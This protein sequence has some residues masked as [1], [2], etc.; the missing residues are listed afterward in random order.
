MQLL[1]SL[2]FKN[3]RQINLFLAAII[4]GIVSYWN[5]RN[6]ILTTPDS[7]AYWEGSISIIEGNKFAFLGGGE[8]Y[9]WPPL[10]S[11]YLTFIQML[12][13]Q[14]GFSLIIAMS[15]ISALNSF[16]WSNYVR[17]IFDQ[18]NSEL[19][20]IALISSLIFVNLFILQCSAVLLAQFMML[21]FIGI[22]FNSL[23]DIRNAIS[24]SKYSL[25]ILIL[26]VAILLGLLTHNSMIIF[27]FATAILLL[28]EYSQSLVRRLL[29]SLFIL[30]I[31]LITWAAV[32]SSLNQTYSHTHPQSLYKHGE[33]ILQTINGIG[34][35]FVS[36]LSQLQNI[37][38]AFGLIFVSF[39]IY[40]L[41]F[42]KKLKLDKFH[43][44]SLLLV[45]IS[46]II[47][48]VLFNIIWIDSQ[49]ADRFL[50]Y[51]LLATVP[52]FLYV[53]R[54]KKV[55][56][57]LVIFLFLGFSSVKNIRNMLYGTVSPVSIAQQEVF[58]NNIR[59]WYYL[60]SR[61]NLVI[62]PESKEI[63]P[64]TFPWMTRWKQLQ[65]PE[66]ERKKVRII[67]ESSKHF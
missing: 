48:F 10:F 64:P 55:I 27:L 5:N 58:D 26:T 25:K 24:L 18:C 37:R 14:T 4:V 56:L 45:M 39:V 59:P 9:Y 53:L 1:S 11:L 52:I 67:S 6:G 61:T 19:K 30:V 16:I 66:S 21:T 28:V 22:I 15:L 47:L 60:S 17:K 62:P 38:Y 34:Y 33:Y 2:N 44:T 8:I 36:S 32:R 42:Q 20:R 23:F 43:I 41:L 29:S 57:Y 35:F 54:E 31:P 50:W 51:L 13:N 7:W 46:F 12:F 63:S 40:I 3:S 65:L 49:L